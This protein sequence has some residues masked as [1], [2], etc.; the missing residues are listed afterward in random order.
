MKLFNPAQIEKIKQVAEKSRAAF[1]PP[2]KSVKSKTIN[3][4]LERISKEVIEYFKDS[5]AILITTKED[6]HQYITDMIE[7]GIAGV[8]CE[9]TGLDRIRDHI[10][11]FSLYCET[12]PEC[13]I[14]NK[15]LVPLFDQPYADQLTYEEVHDELVRL[16]DSDI[17]LVYANADFDLAMMHKDYGVDLSP[18]FYYDVILGWRCMK[19]NEPDNR[20]KILYNK[21]PLKGKGDPKTFSDLFPV[22]L[23][24]YCKPEVAKLYAANDPKLNIKLMNWQLPYCDKT[25]IKCQRNGLE[26]ISDLI[27]NLE[28]PLVSVCHHLHHTGIHIDKAVGNVI[29][30]R[31]RNKYDIQIKKLHSLVQDAIDK[32]GYIPSF[33]ENPPFRHGSEFNPDS[34]PQVKHLLTKILKLPLG[35]DGGTG[36]DYLSTL[37]NPVVD[38][39][40]VV[41]SLKT[42]IGT[43]TDKLP[44]I[45]APD[46]RIHASFKQ[47]GADTGR[48]S[49]ADPNMQNIPSHNVDI[50]HMFR[51]TPEGRKEYKLSKAYL[52]DDKLELTASL[53]NYYSAYTPVGTVKLSDIKVGDI[54]KIRRDKTVIESY[55][56]SHVGQDEKSTADIFIKFSIDKDDCIDIN[57]D[58]WTIDLYTPPYIMMSSD[59]SAQEPRLTAYISNDAK[60]IQAF[61]EGKDI[62]ATIASVAFGFPYEQCLEFHPETREY[63]PDGKARRTEAKSVLLGICYGR[64]VPSVA[65]QLYGH[66]DSLSDEEKVKKAQKVFDAVLTAIPG[67]RDVMNYSQQFAKKYGYVETILGRRRH[68]P[69]M[70]LDEFEFVPMEGYI[71]PD[72]DPLDPSTLD[73]QGGIPDRIKKALLEEFKGYKY[74]GQVVKH[75]KELAEK[76]K[77]KVINNRSKIT[78]ATRQCLNS[79]IQGSAADQTKLAMLLIDNSEEWKR[80][81]ARLL[82]PVH[83]ELIAEAPVDNYEEAGKLLSSLMCEAASFLPFDSKC[84][85]ETTFRWYGLEYPCPFKKPEGL[86]AF[87]MDALNEMSD[88]DI[89]WIQY[90]LTECEYQ[91]PVYKNPDGSKPNGIAAKGVNGVPSDYLAVCIVNYLE[92][93]SITENMFIDHIERIVFNG[94]LENNRRYD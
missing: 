8:D 30:D 44:S 73:N 69:D 27:W 79:R 5:P 66:D 64:S 47:I 57:A 78:D 67:L 80:L 85:V 9:T 20:L 18:R 1:E 36:K 17:K 15:H 70:Q 65:D 4:D 37:S 87:N 24:P 75:G 10:V 43:F 41:R 51:A 52:A 58:S 91:L 90:C 53:P 14:P 2:S 32:S 28:M 60:M 74:F 81:G 38:Q 48:F 82:I 86:T 92:K 22:S 35:K 7:V 77:I 50:R 46:G 89:S 45:V 83:D 26:A 88:N 76:H 11:G 29:K 21:Y 93:Y 31:Y 59:Y 33:S 94:T 72:I 61:V 63:Q 19:E 62:Y 34:V 40:L 54:V 25:N 16:L 6:L 23:F 49:S 71:N 3:Q 56:V 68:I 39:I 12:R 13:Y 42:L 55:L 84:D